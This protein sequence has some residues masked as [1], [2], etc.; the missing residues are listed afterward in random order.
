MRK[1]AQ[2][3]G[4][5]DFKTEKFA[6]NSVLAASHTAEMPPKDQDD[7]IKKIKT[8]GGGEEPAAEP[9]E[10]PAP[11][12][13]AAE[14]APETPKETDEQIMVEMSL[15]D[16]NSKKLMDIYN[17]GGNDRQKVVRLVTLSDNF[18][19]AKGFAEAIKD[20]VDYEDLKYIFDRLKEEGVKVP[21]EEPVQEGLEN[22][23]KLRIF[24]ENIMQEP[25]VKPTTKP[26]TKPSETPEPSRK[27]KPFLPIVTPGVKP[28]PKAQK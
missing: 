5:P 11:T 12:E 14:P 18:E 13:P 26:A 23:E 16:V 27:D 19:D 21:V 15:N 4:Q 9:T 6:I 3:T 22:T 17:R 24:E 1:Y 7:I 28:D 20:H 8:S 10:A 2:D 25:V